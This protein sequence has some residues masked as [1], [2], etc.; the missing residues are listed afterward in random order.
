MSLSSLFVLASCNNSS[1]TKTS[2][3]TTTTT[4]G[5]STITTTTTVAPTTTSTTDGGSVTTTTTTEAIQKQD[6]NITNISDVSKT[7]DGTQIS[8]PTYN[9]LGDGDVTIEYKVQG[10]DDS[11]Y[12]SVAPSE[13]G[14]Y[15]LRISVGETASYNAGSATKDFAIT[16]TNEEIMRVSLNPSLEFIIDVYGKV[17]AVNALNDEGNFIKG[18][19]DFIGKTKLE[20]AN[21]FIDKINN[22]G[23][24]ETVNDKTFDLELNNEQVL[25][26][27]KAKVLEHLD[28]INV[29][30]EVNT[31]TITSADLKDKLSQIMEYSQ[32]ELDSMTDSELISNFAESRKDTKDINSKELKDLYELGRAIAVSVAK[33][34]YVCQLMGDNVEYANAKA[35]LT[36]YQ[37]AIKESWNIFLPFYEFSTLNSS[38]NYMI[39]KNA[40][41]KA[42]EEYLEVAKTDNVFLK[43]QYETG[44]NNIKTSIN[45]AYSSI[46]AQFDHIV[47]Q[48][49]TISTNLDTYATQIEAVLEGKDENV[50]EVVENAK[51]TLFENMEDNLDEYNFD[52]W[53]LTNVKA[54]GEMEYYYVDNANKK[55]Y[56]FNKNIYQSNT[57]FVCYVYDGTYT[58]DELANQKPYDFYSY[59]VTGNQINL[60]LDYVKYNILHFTINQDKSLELPVAKGTLNYLFYAAQGPQDY[61]MAFNT[62]S[63]QKIV[64]QFIGNYTKEDIESGKVFYNYQYTWKEENNLIVMTSGGVDTK[65]EVEDDGITLKI[66]VLKID[67]AEFKYV[68]HDD[69]G[70]TYAFIEG[71]SLKVVYYYY[72]LY[73]LQEIIDEK[74]EPDQGQDGSITWTKENEIITC[75]GQEFTINADNTLS[76][77]TSGGSGQV[78]STRQFKY[79]YKDST[80][81]YLFIIDTDGSTNEKT[82]ICNYYSKVYDNITEA[83]SDTNPSIQYS[84][85]E[86][87]STVKVLSG[88]ATML[89]LSKDGNNLKK[90]EI[91]SKEFK[92]IYS[93][94]FSFALYVINGED[95][96]CYVY[97]S[98]VEKTDLDTANPIAEI[99]WYEKGEGDNKIITASN[100]DYTVDTDGETLI[101]AY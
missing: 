25:L 70:C 53:N 74:I 99:E 30:A 3:I 91:T 45:N 89:K 22:L 52:V 4:G 7:Y 92:Y 20:A 1:E 33:M 55:T 8:E 64:Y 100:T 62:V 43:S 41:A 24:L 79:F 59:Y 18:L 101:M 68:Y 98:F 17:E 81:S 10:S 71:T 95:K 54:Y 36:A 57:Q 67:G 29:T 15:T 94:S 88:K 13:L 23:Y 82:Y 83:Q 9:K 80:A 69:Y 97:N 27:L 31:N 34:N 38:S 56:S 6:Q 49:N 85:S 39:L 26:A 35:A 93:G 73:T 37:N 14:K 72:D 2:E 42:K 19:V 50:K 63:G 28:A 48:L 58:K 78:A 76:K 86:T 47:S 65:L 90:Y 21:L 96:V 87:N 16:N 44:L 5:V 66:Y 75:M 12:S 40:Y 84:W 11:T 60:T 46:K 61:T 77:Y 51:K 32:D